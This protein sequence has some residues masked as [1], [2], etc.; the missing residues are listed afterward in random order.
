[1]SLQHHQL[2][3]R[4][5]SL[6]LGNQLSSW[7]D[8]ELL[9]DASRGSHVWNGCWLPNPWQHLM[10]LRSLKLELHSPGLHMRTPVRSD[11]TNLNNPIDIT[12]CACLFVQFSATS[13]KIEKIINV[14][15]SKFR[16]HLLWADLENTKTIIFNHIQPNYVQQI[17]MPR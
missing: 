3:T 5:P 16:A 2:G 11:I 8:W 14:L 9:F 10:P 12:F 7:S 4:Y 6:T 17:R 15:C 13:L 1:M